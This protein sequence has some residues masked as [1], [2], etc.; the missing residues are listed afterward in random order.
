MESLSDNATMNHEEKH[1]DLKYS[2]NPPHVS[3]KSRHRAVKRNGSIRRNL[4]VPTL[5][6]KRRQKLIDEFKSNT[7]ALVS[8]NN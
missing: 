6:E 1:D 2:K 4:Q 5:S 8:N 7:N 3:Q